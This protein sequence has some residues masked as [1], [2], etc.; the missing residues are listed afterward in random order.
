MSKRA[1][2][3]ARNNNLRPVKILD[4]TGKPI[5]N[6]PIPEKVD[7]GL[8]PNLRNNYASGETKER[9]AKRQELLKA[10]AEHLILYLEDNTFSENEKS[11]SYIDFYHTFKLE[12]KHIWGLQDLLIK[13]SPEDRR[14]LIVQ[15]DKYNLPFFTIIRSIHKPD[16][17]SGPNLP[18]NYD[19]AM[20]WLNGVGLNGDSDTLNGAGKNG[21]NGIS[22]NERTVQPVTVLE[23]PDDRPVK[24]PPKPQKVETVEEKLIAYIEHKCPNQT[25]SLFDVAQVIHG[26]N[27]S[28]PMLNKRVKK[29]G[30]ELVESG[31][32][33]LTINKIPV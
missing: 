3:R 5:D 14:W 2:K 9:I 10:A 15:Y 32:F 24:L 7:Q 26:W 29:Y 18:T 6:S 30:I 8:Y 1:K 19:K 21:L 27:Y 16:N 12:E 11:I 4:P 28:V 20:T 33:M 17:Y 25:I 13:T 31:D 22:L 23:V